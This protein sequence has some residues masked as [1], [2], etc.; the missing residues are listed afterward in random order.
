MADEPV[1]VASEDKSDP[2]WEALE[3]ERKARAALE[4]GMKSL[5]ERLERTRSE[6]ASVQLPPAT[7]VQ[8]RDS[9][10]RQAARPWW[11][12][13][14][15]GFLAF[16]I[17]AVSA[18]ALFVRMLHTSSTEDKMLD[19]M[20]TILFSTCL[21][22]VYQYTF[23]SSRGSSAKDEVQN[24]VIDKL[25][26]PVTVPGTTSTTTTTAKTGEG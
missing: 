13:D 6:L 15:Q 19:T 23:G 11:A 8:S 1:E 10:W 24:K 18:A 16:A 3:D 25:V 20:I 17:V 12:L 26:P 7:I 22:T 5:T 14:A 2:W 9:V 4:G 21:V